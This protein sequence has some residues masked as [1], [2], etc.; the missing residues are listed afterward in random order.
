MN[1]S[2][3][4]Y[5]LQPLE[6]LYRDATARGKRESAAKLRQSLEEFR[7]ELR[8]GRT[9][10]LEYRQVDDEPLIMRQ[11]FSEADL[12]RWIGTRFPRLGEFAQ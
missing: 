3:I 7:Y 11:I 8:L 2:P 10:L 1:E 6:E 9:L 4:R 5:D 12:D